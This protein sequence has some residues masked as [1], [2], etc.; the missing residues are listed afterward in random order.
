MKKAYL[1]FLLLTITNVTF[2]IEYDNSCDPCRVFKMPSKVS[3]IKSLNKKEVPLGMYYD[4]KTK[5]S[6]ILADNETLN[7]IGVYN[8]VILSNH[9][10]NA[11]TGID[12]TDMTD[13]FVIALL[14]HN[15]E[16]IECLRQ[17]GYLK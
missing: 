16:A 4:G 2:N 15:P 17:N 5:I 13:K 8:Q 14:S 6:T 1:S 10:F 7:P 3:I 12:V 11:K 9:D